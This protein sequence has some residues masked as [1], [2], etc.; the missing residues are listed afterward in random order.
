MHG[1]LPPRA[2]PLEL[3]FRDNARKSPDWVRF[4]EILRLPL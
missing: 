1:S 4:T 3:R 2:G